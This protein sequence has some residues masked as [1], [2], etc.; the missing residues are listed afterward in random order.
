M[1]RKFF[2]LSDGVFSVT[3]NYRRRA[4]EVTDFRTCLPQQDYGIILTVT[5]QC[6][7]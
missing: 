3:L 7:A 5:N 4:E 6:R 2:A 1:R